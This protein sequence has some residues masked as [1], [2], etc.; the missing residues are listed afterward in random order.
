MP[1]TQAT[2]ARDRMLQG[3]TATAQSA[4]DPS[5]VMQ[6]ADQIEMDQEMEDAILE[7]EQN[8]L[9]IDNITAQLP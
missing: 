5:T 1:C 4:P 9:F 7:E 3:A 6:S 2:A 8:H